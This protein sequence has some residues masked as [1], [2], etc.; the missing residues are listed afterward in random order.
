M[1]KGMV[2]GFSKSRWHVP[3]Q[4][5]GVTLATI[6]YFLGHAHGGREFAE[7]AHSSFATYVVL[8]LIC[9]VCLGVYLK[10]H[11]EKGL[12]KWL[13]PISVK[14]HRTLGVLVP[15]IGYAQIVLGVITMNGWCRF[16]SFLFYFIFGL[17]FFFYFYL[18]IH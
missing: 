18:Y 16:L 17:F 15:I 6:G 11:W 5:L 3:V 8:F 7:N 13:R 14:F 4:A 2:L 1:Y 10:L 9:Q 12:N